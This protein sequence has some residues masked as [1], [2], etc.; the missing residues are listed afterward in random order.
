VKCSGLPGI[1]I[2][3]R[4]AIDDFE[5]GFAFQFEWDDAFDQFRSEAAP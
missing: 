2:V 5:L 4:T 3:Q 1:T